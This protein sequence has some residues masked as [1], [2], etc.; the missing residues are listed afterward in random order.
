M[1][2]LSF[3]SSKGFPTPRLPH[4]LHA[5]GLESGHIPDSAI[6]ASSEIAVNGKAANARLHLQNGLGAWTTL[7]LDKFQWLQVNFGNWTTVGRVAIQGR[8]MAAEWVTSLSLSSSYDGMF[9][10]DYQEEG[11]KKVCFRKCHQFNLM[12]RDK[13]LHFYIEFKIA[14]MPIS[15]RKIKLTI[16]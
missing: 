15:P 1:N 12:L 7:K 6:T 16:N 5:L 9:F 8:Y 10:D 14:N 4:C 2:T 3:F 13:R 11:S